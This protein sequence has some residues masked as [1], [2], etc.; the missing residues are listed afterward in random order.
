[1]TLFLVHRATL[2]DF[3]MIYVLGFEVNK[4]SKI[5]IKILSVAKYNESDIKNI[6]APIVDDPII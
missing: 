6:K 3:L 4:L 5:L 2:R 1:M